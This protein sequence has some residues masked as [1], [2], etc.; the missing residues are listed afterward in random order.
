MEMDVKLNA[1]LLIAS[2]YDNDCCLNLP[3]LLL[4]VCFS[5]C[6]DFRLDILR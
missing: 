1:R 3:N 4:A 2:K 5:Q 6:L